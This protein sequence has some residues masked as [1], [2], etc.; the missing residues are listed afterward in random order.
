MAP[1][2]P[3]AP[4]RMAA[5]R[6]RT[7]EPATEEPVARIRPS[8]RRPSARRD[9]RATLGGMAHG[10]KP[11]AAAPADMPSYWLVYFTVD[12]V[13]AAHRRAIGLG[14][15]ERVAPQDFPGGRFSVAADPD[16]AGF[17]LLKSAPR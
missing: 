2:G 9:G 16:G 15:T 10:R 11:P 4:A 1:E 3:M 8:K 13:D 6:V 17:D 5:S 12:D 14:G 7:R